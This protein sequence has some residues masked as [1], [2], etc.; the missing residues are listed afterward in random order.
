MKIPK[1]PK[2]KRARKP[3]C[4]HGPEVWALARAAYLA[5][6]SA[7]SLSERLGLGV[8]AIR[9][10]ITREGWTKRSLTAAR[11]AVILAEAATEAE[12]RA[13]REAALE[14]EPP[15]E[16]REAARAALDEAVRLMRVGRT[17]EALATARVA[18]VVGRAAG[19]L[20]ALPKASQGEG[21]DDE[22]AFEAV[23]RKVLGL[24]SPSTEVDGE[25]R[26]TRERRPGGGGAGGEGGA[27]GP[28]FDTALPPPDRCAVCPPRSPDANG[29]VSS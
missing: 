10:R 5:G 4:Y 2:P 11:D 14:G 15:M 27:E 23:R 21:F 20:P 24:T 28:L 16:P 3:Y 25:D 17:S 19:R 18:E 6:E 22:A 8:P 9:Q 1:T 12:A 26:S 13:A 7:A 29:E